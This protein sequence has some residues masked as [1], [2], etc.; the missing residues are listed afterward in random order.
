MT[1]FK[2]SIKISFQLSCDNMSENILEY[3]FTHILT[4]ETC[5]FLLLTEMSKIKDK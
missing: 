2:D 1:I 3:V 4:Q 5:T